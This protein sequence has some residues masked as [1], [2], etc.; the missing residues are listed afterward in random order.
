MR[1][2]QDDLRRY[3]EAQTQIEAYPLFVPE[4]VQLPA[5]AYTLEDAGRNV[6]SDQ[7]K[8]SVSDHTYTVQVCDNRFDSVK[9]IAQQVID[10]FDGKGFTHEQTEV[11][12]SQVTSVSDATNHDLDLYFRIITFTL[13]VREA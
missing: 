2:I 12:T 11:L 4:S 5:I 8:T 7:Y 1:M 10:L 3:I 6:G 9:N 13:I